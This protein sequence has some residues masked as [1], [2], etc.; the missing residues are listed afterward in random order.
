MVFPSNFVANLF[1]FKPEKGLGVAMQG[2]HLEVSEAE[3]QDV[4]VD[5]KS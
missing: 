2:A 1:H 5:L 4:K 3:M